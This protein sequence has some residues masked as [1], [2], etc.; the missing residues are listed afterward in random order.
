MKKIRNSRKGFTLTEIVLVVAIVVLL[1]SVTVVGIAATLHKKD[2][3]DANMDERELRLNTSWIEVDHIRPAKENAGKAPEHTPDPA[4]VDAEV[5][6]LIDKWKAEGYSDED[7]DITWDIDNKYKTGAK[8]KPGATPN[9]VN[10]GDATTT[11]GDTTNSGTTSGGT[12]NSG[13]TANDNTTNEGTQQGQQ[14]QGQQNQGQ[15]GQQS[16]NNN[17]GNVVSSQVVSSVNSYTYW[18]DGAG[19]L[20]IN[21]NDSG[22]ATANTVTL[23]FQVNDGNITAINNLNNYKPDISYNGNTATVVIDKN[24]VDEWKK[25]AWNN[26]SFADN[27]EKKLKPQFSISGGKDTQVTLVSATY[28]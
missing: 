3:L 12:T 9:K 14:G 20:T 18:N 24:K 6:K 25:N 15:Q 16:G 8:L 2:E 21:T 7:I 23:V 4:A 27:G 13:T 28:G 17:S 10:N 1:S 5:Q 22:L 19:E 26:G 11:N